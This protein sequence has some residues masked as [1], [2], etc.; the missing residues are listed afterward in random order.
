L[1]GL[2]VGAGDVV[3]DLEAELVRG[4]CVA[5][6]SVR[7]ARSRW[8][9]RCAVSGRRHR[10]GRSRDAIG[11]SASPAVAQP[12]AAGAYGVQ[13]PGAHMARWPA[14]GAEAPGA[15]GDSTTPPL[16]ASDAPSEPLIPQYATFGFDAQAKHPRAKSMHS[17]GWGREAAWPFPG[18]S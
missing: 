17:I 13:T 16:G 15:A 11:T 7:V 12:R 18:T 3:Q 9:S 6:A 2:G 5:H 4:H 14:L 10:C 1:G 8:A